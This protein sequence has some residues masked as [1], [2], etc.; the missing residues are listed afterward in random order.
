MKRYSREREAKRG[1]KRAWRV[2]IKRAE[3]NRG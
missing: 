2:R 1:Q 3:L